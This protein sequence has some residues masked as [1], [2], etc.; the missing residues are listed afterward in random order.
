MACI[1]LDLVTGFLGSG[2]TTLVN[3]LLR[4][5]A[6][7]RAMVVVNEFG[8][9][10]LDHLLV[11]GSQDQVVLLDSGCLCCAASGSLPDTLLDLFAGMSS[12]RVPA[13][14]RLIVETSGLADPAPLIAG[15]LG[16]SALENRCRL[17]QVVTLVDAVNAGA[18]AQ[19]YAEVR[20]Q[21]ALADRILVTKLGAP[22][23]ATFAQV[24]ALVE[25]LGAQA[26]AIPHAMGD[27][28]EQHFAP[29]RKEP[30]AGAAAPQGLL[31]R[32]PLRP[33]YGEHGPGRARIASRTWRVR[34]PIEW[35]T[36]A[37]WSGAMRERFG[38][39]LLRCK[40][41]LALGSD[42][43]LCVVQ[44]VQGYFAKPERLPAWP[45]AAGEGFVVCIGE[46]IDAAELEVVMGTLDVVPSEER[47]TG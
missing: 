9:V 39:R 17:N 33:Q 14:D 7:S 26:P 22:D 38:K 6:F 41:L 44:G 20:R 35:S 18:N 3:A 8:E 42:A 27:D 47:T 1:P 30:A 23:A 31:T 5:P 2:K 29:L 43:Q 46:G 32:G 24:E 45:S 36:Y 34:G 21:I 19:A 15:L 40:G 37:A 10:G 11:T 12:G 25:R 16:D 13:F 4:N 28:V